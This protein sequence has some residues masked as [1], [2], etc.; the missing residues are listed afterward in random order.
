MVGGDAQDDTIVIKVPHEFFTSGKCVMNVEVGVVDGAALPQ[1]QPVVTVEQ[2]HQII[3]DDVC[4]MCPYGNKPTSQPCKDNS[5]RC[6]AAYRRQAEAIIDF[7][8]A[9]PDQEKGL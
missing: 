1:V 6:H 4:G 8:A 5:D 2:I 7:L 9:Q 3:R